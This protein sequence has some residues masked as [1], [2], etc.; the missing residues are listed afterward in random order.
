M[1]TSYSQSNDTKK[2]A[3]RLGDTREGRDGGHHQQR[4][5]PLG[6]EV[7]IE[8]VVDNL[9]LPGAIL[10]GIGRMTIGMVCMRTD[11]AGRWRLSCDFGGEIT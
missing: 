8:G 2:A 3:N 6:P 4:P 5:R 1:P 11:E 7:Q 9:E 10:D